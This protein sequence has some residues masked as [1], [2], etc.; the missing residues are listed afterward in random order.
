MALVRRV[1]AALLAELMG[2]AETRR[3][4]RRRMIAAFAVALIGQLARLVARE[5]RVFGDGPPPLAWWTTLAIAIA[6]FA[7]AAYELRCV[8]ALDRRMGALGR[9]IARMV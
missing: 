2:L 6:A 5:G 9:T 8:R 7:F 1:R 3:A 4:H